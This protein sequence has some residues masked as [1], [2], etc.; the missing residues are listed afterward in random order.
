MV[1][2]PTRWNECNKR[3]FEVFP[4]GIFSNIRSGCDHEIRTDK[5]T[6]MHLSFYVYII[7]KET[8]KIAS[9]SNFLKENDIL[10]KFENCTLKNRYLNYQTLYR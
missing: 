2:F 6:S 3:Y 8:N 5:T 7:L 4:N 1:Q 9:N 10:L